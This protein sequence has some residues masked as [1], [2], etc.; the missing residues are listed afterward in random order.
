MAAR[1][2]SICGTVFF[3]GTLLFYNV[4]QAEAAPLPETAGTSTPV[5]KSSVTFDLKSDNPGRLTF[6]G[7][8]SADLFTKETSESFKGALDQDYVSQ[9]NNKFPLGFL[10]ASPTNQPW[11]GTMWTRDA[12]TF[13]REL[14]SWGYFAHAGQVAE[15]VIDYV[16]TNSEGFVEFPR[17]IDPQLGAVSGSEM[18]GQAAT[19]ISMVALW[20]RLPAEDP[21]RARLFGFLH[22]PSS[23]VQGIHFF[24]QHGP[25][26]PG[27][28]EFG[29]GKGHDNYNVIQNNLC[30]LALLSAADMEEEAGD[31]SVAKT[32]RKDAKRLFANIEKCLVNKRGAWIWGIETNTM[33]P[34]KTDLDSASNSGGGGLNGVI[35]MSAD[36]LGNDPATWPW[37]GAMVH[38][39]KTFQDLYNFPLRKEQFEKYGFWAQMNYTHKGLL[40]SPSYGQGYALQDMLL[41]DKMDMAEHGLE[42][43]TDGTYKAPH[44]IWSLNKDHY[45]RTSPYYFY[46]RMYSSEALGQV[47]LTAG[48]GP[49]NLVNVSEPLKVARLIAGVDDTSS[50]V[51]KIIPRLPPSWSGYRMENWP[52]YT[53]HG[54][55]RAD[56][57]CEK[58]DGKFNFV[59][60]VK[61]GGAIPK[62]SVRLPETKGTVWKKKGNAKKIEFISSLRFVRV[63]TF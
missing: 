63:L 46:E 23:P 36:V 17:Y 25:L 49:L 44:I 55:V 53:S 54:L 39:E 48:C 18:D 13:M 45:Q 43:L 37:Q 5:L 33:Q 41:M 24:L 2:N 22:Q 50:D 7:S 29:G 3:L 31:R 38:G 57:S 14:V 8:A 51:V 35:C 15:C 40:T 21:F 62:L 10:N 56:I 6:W 42:F 59:L 26:V 58:K 11:Y 52:I 9:K 4:F 32:Y 60:Q 1:M 16:G 30:A 47:E 61:Q 19:I 20:R 27:S 28:G 12:G 34:N